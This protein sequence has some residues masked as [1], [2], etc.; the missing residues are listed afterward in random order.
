MA[1][2]TSNTYHRW[3][4]L[5]GLELLRAQRHTTSFPWHT[6]NTFNIALILQETFSIQ[7]PDALIKS[8]VGTLSI[9]NPD[10]VHATPCQTAIGNTFLT[11]YVSPDVLSAL[12]QGCSV[13][14]P[15]RTICDNALFAEF[16]LLANRLP[17]DYPDWEARFLRTLRR[18]TRTYAT[19]EATDA[20]TTRLF[21]SFIEEVDINTFSL[22]KA[23]R[24]F[25][26]N[27][28]KFLRLF[29][30]ETGL[31]PHHFVLLKRIERSKELLAE[32]YDIL[33]A[34]IRSG[35]YDAPHLYR[36]FRK[37]TGVTPQAYQQV[38]PE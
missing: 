20:Q 35:F 16:Y 15:D 12:N 1:Q 19:E 2:P 23:A 7:L 13:F 8:P 4:L 24:Q 29:K 22:D 10:E 38:L 26:L 36:H 17:S 11:F 14:F 18:L 30:Q 32:G 3:P 27:K 33:E 6:H 5:D 37:F 34:A 31:T 28:Y 25:G 21:K 9:T